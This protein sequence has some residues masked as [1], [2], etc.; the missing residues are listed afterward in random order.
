MTKLS[1]NKSAYPVYLTIGNISKAYRRQATKHATIVIGYLPI[2]EFKDVPSKVLRTRLKGELIHAAMALL[3][4][5][6]EEAGR[7]GVEM[8]CADGRLHRIYPLLVAFVGDWP[9]QCDMACVVRSGCPKCLKRKAGRGDE[10]KAAT[11]TRLSTLAAV[12]RY[13]ETG[14]KAALDGLGLKPWWPWWANLPSTEF[15][16]CITPDLLH[17][18]HKGLFKGHAM[19]W[20]QQKLGKRVVDGRYMSMPCASGLCH[21]KRGIS[22]VEQW[23]GCEAK[24]MMKTFLPLIAE[25]HSVNNDLAAFIRTLLDFSYIAHAARL[26]ETELEELQGAHTEMHQLNCGL[27]SSGVYQGLGRLDKIPKW[28]MISHYADSIR[29]L[30]TPDRYNTKAPEYLHIVYV[31]RGWAA[32]NK[33]DAIQQIIKY[34][35]RL[36]ALQIHRAH[37]DEFYGPQERRGGP[38]KTAVF[39]D[40]EE[41]EYD[42]EDGEGEPWEDMED[43]EDE[44]DGEEGR[45]RPTMF[46]VS[47]IEHPAPEFAIAMRPTK[48]ATLPELVD[49]YGATSLKQALRCF[50]RPYTHGHYYI[51][52]H[53]LFDVWHKLTLSH[54]PLSFAPDEPS[55]RDIIR[56]R[57]PVHDERGRLR[58]RCE[59]AFDTALF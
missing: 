29:E 48:R 22:A 12:D 52:R 24:E 30:G 42:P 51:L 14:R 39:I 58:N 9:E 18:L 50:L 45:R 23:T 41:G 21:F 35:Q 40:D 46:D 33:R 6:L 34:C 5:P 25:D 19:R 26:T 37:L 15:A 11:R 8:W 44:E 43:E 16:T 7:E 38:T 32:S 2:D 31:K 1:G 54:H 57:P 4:E 47:E 56:V 27:V 17:Q 36:E 59:P 49:V 3:M 55:Q 28:H 20:I 53:E 10:R 13:L